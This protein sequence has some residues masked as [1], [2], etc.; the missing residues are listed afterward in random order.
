MEQGLGKK[1]KNS[2]AEEAEKKHTRRCWKDSSHKWVITALCL[3]MLVAI[4]YTSLYGIFRREAEAN[5]DNPLESLNTMSYLYQNSYVLYRDLY[6][7]QNQTNIS[8]HELYLTSGEHFK[9]LMDT[10]FF[11]EAMKGDY[12]YNQLPDVVTEEEMAQAMGAA[13]YLDEHLAEVEDSF[14]Q[15]NS[16]FD[17]LIEDVNTGA[18]YSNLPY[19]EINSFDQYFYVQF[20]FDEYGNVTV[21]ST[22]LGN[23]VT[24]IRKNANE[25]V[26][27]CDLNNLIEQNR[28]YEAVENVR[29]QMPV[30]CRV[31]FCISREA[32]Q[33]FNAADTYNNI[34]VY[35]NNGETINLAYSQSMSWYE[36]YN[37]TS[38]GEVYALMVLAVMLVAFFLPVRL[39]GEP[40]KE[41]K[42]LFPWVELL[43]LIGMLSISLGSAVVSMVSWVCNG[44]AISNLSRYLSEAAFVPVYFINIIFLTLLFLCA[45]YTGICA[46][47]VREL[48]IKEY[49]K[50]RLFFYQI[51]PYLKKK[52]L[53]LYD[54]LSHFDVTR[55]ANHLILKIVLVNAVV[56]FIIGSLWVGGFTIAVIYSVLLYFLLR[57]YISDLQKKYSIL[58]QATNEI[59]QGNLN[60]TINEDLGVFEPFKPQVI[61]IQEGFKNAVEEEVK[62]QRM[63]SELITNVSHDLKT[64]LTAIITYINLLKEEN[65]TEEQR[66]EYL[67]TLER[68]S[69]RL[70]GLIED[71]FE[72]SKANSN[73]ITLNIMDVDI[74]SLVKQVELEMSDKLSEAGL[75]VR[76]NLPDEKYILPLDSQKTYRIYENLFGNVVKYALPGT[77]VYVT[78]NVLA[79]G[80]E[81]TLKNITAQELHVTPEELTERFVR[82]DASRNTEGSGLGLAIAK[83]FTELQ[84]G[85]F[86]IRLDG[87]LFKAVTI[88]KKPE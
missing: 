23:D 13:R 17:Y 10:Q 29:A 70:K 9:E 81:I 80:I 24:R 6:N 25:I 30:N 71:L 58:L 53:G 85:A 56:L 72:V 67:N 88:W 82:G 28:G 12:D 11:E 35:Y 1:Q 69:L 41:R 26:R 64:P 44:E 61:R 38:C 42:L 33:K 16:V 49:L 84:G 19:K 87:D 40:W 34:A 36:A 20:L 66:K 14:G 43:V 27:I 18:Y 77:R 62:S 3:S 86:E 75:E 48:G 7:R 8:Y 22:I 79:N 52:T 55:K 4:L 47:S 21:G 83:S 57:K 59:A 15:L 50:K 68:K 76:M 5:V 2:I 46:R 39:V 73:N 74:I 60:V 32:W 65:I 63:K 31:T 78:A 54:E 37:N 51:F 45:A